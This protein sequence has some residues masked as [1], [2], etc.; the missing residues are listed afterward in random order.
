MAEFQ[1]L[2]PR[3]VAEEVYDILRQKIL[4]CD[5]S[6]GERVDVGSI[7]NQLGI[8]R[9]PVKDAL[10]RLSE[11]GLIEIH[12]RKGTFVTRIS[13]RDVRETFEV[14]AALE[15]KACQLLS[16]KISQ[17]LIRHLRELNEAMFADNLDMLTHAKLNNEFHRLIVE[18]TGNQK[19][20]KMYSE[21]NAQM[22]IARVHFRSVTWRSRGPR[23]VEEHDAIVDAMIENRPEDARRVMEEH[24]AEAMNRLIEQMADAEEPAHDQA[25]EAVEGGK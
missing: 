14:R 2:N 23:V 3:R 9:T 22:Q 8:S 17:P 25:T 19:L 1:V 6:P 13:P 10:Q 12:A 24:I 4:A 20:L 15:G 21:L 7:S 11:Q 5:L 16:G 18:H